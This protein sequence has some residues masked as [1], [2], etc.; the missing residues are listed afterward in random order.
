M[1]SIYF[2]TSIEV[3]YVYIPLNLL[4][5]FAN[6]VNLMECAI[7]FPLMVH[8]ILSMFEKNTCTL[9]MGPCLTYILSLVQ[10]QQQI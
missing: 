7:T 2:H 6:C 1:S 9:A 5:N 10:H 4:S 8:N 3:Y